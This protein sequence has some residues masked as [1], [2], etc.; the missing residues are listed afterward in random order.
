[1]ILYHVTHPDNLP[2]IYKDGL[3]PQIGA[4][5]EKLGEQ[6]PRVYLFTD[7][8]AMDTALACWLGQ[9]WE[10]LYGEDAECCSL[11]IDLPDDFPVFNEG[12]GYEVVSYQEIPPR[13]I[14]FF[15]DE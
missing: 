9:E 15:R 7:T 11:I 3:I 14:K 12:V 13:Y 8:E 1:M 2:S 5:S 4:L 10:E 6:L